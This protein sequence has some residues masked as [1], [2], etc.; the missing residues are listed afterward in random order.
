MNSTILRTNRSNEFQSFKQFVDDSS[1]IIIT[2]H[3]N[4]DA[5]A[6]GSTIAMQEYLLSIGKKCTI[7][8]CDKAPYN[9]RFIDSDNRIVHYNPETDV[10]LLT[11]A[12]LVIIL[13]VNTYVRLKK[14]GE[15]LQL[16]SKKTILIDHHHDPV[17]EANL[18]IVDTDCP[19]T[20]ELLYT[21]FSCDS[22]FTPTTKLASAIYAGMYTD[23]GGFRFTR[24]DSETF[25]IAAELVQFGANPVTIYD[26]IINSSP[27]GRIKLVG[28]V[29]QSMRLY[30]EEKICIVSISQQDFLETKTTLEHAD[31]IIAS[32]LEIK[33]VKLAVMMIEDV[34]RIKL[35]FRSKGDFPANQVAKI[36]GGGG[37]FN[38]A[39]GTLP[40]ELTLDEA[41][42]KITTAL[43]DFSKYL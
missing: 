25:L 10:E 22:E 40:V 32:L 4:P 41:A 9:L 26:E 28:K 39:G 17:I 14:V 8:L 1:S 18:S 12:D 15:K 34:N 42:E 5:D 16:L 3:Q 37:H 43:N 20:C 38:A 23:T 19:S 6:I 29:Y 35:S 24:T 2:S 7:V 36:F 21:L 30:F 13:D 33:G 11:L 27:I 31:G